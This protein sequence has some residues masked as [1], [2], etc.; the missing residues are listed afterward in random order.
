MLICHYISDTN[1]VGN[2][3]LRDEHSTTSS[4]S[5]DVTKLVFQSVLL[6]I[7]TFANLL[8]PMLLVGHIDGHNIVIGCWFEEHYR[9]G[10]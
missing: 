7:Q 9:S 10:T 2:V 3:S 1:I 5:I 8:S 4:R 6:H